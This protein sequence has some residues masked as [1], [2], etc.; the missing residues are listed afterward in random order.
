MVYIQASSTY[1]LTRQRPRSRWFVRERR[2][3]SF[4]VVEFYGPDW[5][6]LIDNTVTK[7][8]GLRD[9]VV[10]WLRLGRLNRWTD[11]YGI[12]YGVLWWAIKAHF[13]LM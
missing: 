4:A 1:P 9:S 6:V 13:I 7:S 3:P 8:D 10:A 2:T 5:L 11:L 12:R